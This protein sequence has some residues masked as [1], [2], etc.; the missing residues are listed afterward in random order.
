MSRTSFQ[1]VPVLTEMRPP[2]GE[3]GPQVRV[4]RD[5]RQV[6]ARQWDSLLGPEDLQVSHRFIRTCQESSV[7][8]AEYWHVMVHDAN[9]LCCVATLSRFHISLDVLC[10]GWTRAAIR[11]VRRF[12]WGFLRIPMLFCGLPV[13]FGQPGLRIRDDADAPFAIRQVAQTM[14]DVARRTGTS[15]LCFKEFSPAQAVDMETLE[16]AGYF[17][18]LSLPTCSLPIH[19]D[20]FDDYLGALRSGYRRQI[21]MSLQVARQ[22]GLQVRRLEEVSPCAEVLFRLYE[23][24]VDRAAH[25]L[26]RLNLSFF[27]NLGRN[28]RGQC[29]VLL[30]ERRGQP[31]AS[32]LMLRTPD[33]ATFLLA[34]LDYERHQQYQTYQNLVI[35]VLREA[36][37]LGVKRLEM[38]QTSYA[39]KGR[40]GTVTIPRYVYHRHRQPLR[41]ALFKTVSPWLFPQVDCRERRVFRRGNPWLAP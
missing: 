23:Q 15:F 17:R 40:L 37:R 31:L 3:F 36:I 21:K 38:G 25:R 18:A 11:T 34:G 10:Q 5:I 30:M 22:S 28:L 29:Q 26:E 20:T 19:W 13:S 9:G 8:N 33:V 32:A 41:H 12:Y 4:F 16:E 39:M 27:E 7:E 1:R 35:E 6:D 14:E 2:P 24:V